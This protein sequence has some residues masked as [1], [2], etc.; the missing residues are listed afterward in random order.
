MESILTNLVNDVGKA[1]TQVDIS[2]QN[3]GSLSHTWHVDGITEI[4]IFKMFSF[5]NT[6]NFFD[7]T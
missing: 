4:D 7:M 3:P 5:N 6:W 1:I 2:F